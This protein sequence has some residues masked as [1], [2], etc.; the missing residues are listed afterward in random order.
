MSPAMPPSPVC[1]WLAQGRRNNG[2]YGMISGTR[3][4]RVFRDP[5]GFK[6]RNF[7]NVDD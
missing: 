7:F 3:S 2:A 1:N 6:K 5:R 4:R